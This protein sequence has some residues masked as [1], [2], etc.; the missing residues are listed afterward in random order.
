VTNG[1]RVFRFLTKEKQFARLPD[2]RRSAG[3][4]SAEPSAHRVMIFVLRSD[5]SKM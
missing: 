4:A 1:L 2:R 5:A 3:V